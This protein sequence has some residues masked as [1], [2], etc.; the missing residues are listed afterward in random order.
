M[1]VVVIVEG[2]RQGETQRD[3]SLGDFISITMANGNG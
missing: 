3:Y 1:D 2:V